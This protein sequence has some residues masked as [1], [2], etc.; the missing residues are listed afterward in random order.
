MSDSSL[1]KLRA[2]IVHLAILT[3]DL[4]P[5]IDLICA[6]N[7][8]RNAEQYHH[9]NG[10]EDWQLLDV[11]PVCRYCHSL[12]DLIRNHEDIEWDLPEVQNLFAAIEREK[13]NHHPRRLYLSKE[14]KS[15]ESRCRYLVSR[16]GINPVVI[17]SD[18]WISAFSEYMSNKQVDHNIALTIECVLCGC[19]LSWSSDDC[20]CPC[21]KEI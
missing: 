20:T 21:H 18:M 15:T 11:I 16:T 19:S 8:G 14:I 9:F 4:R 5:P 1:L 6:W 12:A 13:I 2:K 7:C 17:F 3:K 10:Y